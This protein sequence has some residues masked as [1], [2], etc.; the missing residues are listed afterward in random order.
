MEVINTTDFFGSS[1]V[2]IEAKI[3]D[4][5]TF[6]SDPDF[7]I[8]YTPYSYY[9]GGSTFTGGSVAGPT[10]DHDWTKEGSVYT[11]TFPLGGLNG[12]YVWR[13]HAEV[14][15]S[16]EGA[17][18]DHNK[19]QEVNMSTVG[20]TWE[21]LLYQYD[22]AP[23]AA[24]FS[25]GDSVEMVS[26]NDKGVVAWGRP[27]APA[28]LTADYSGETDNQWTYAVVTQ[29]CSDITRWESQIQ[30]DTSN[31]VTNPNG[32][33][34]TSGMGGNT[35]DAGEEVNYYSARAVV[36]KVKPWQNYNIWNLD[37]DSLVEDVAQT[38]LSA[39]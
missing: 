16:L 26:N 12:R 2:G 15:G 20:D 6:S 23:N 21:A 30:A 5:R 36:L 18:G 22:P 35:F 11:C 34:D 1:V 33:Y 14:N 37:T 29:G 10:G 13:V 32:C 19:F 38:A 7:S 3:L 9:G 39:L 4:T 28:S 31:T 27:P 17:L 25:R 24:Q 8:S